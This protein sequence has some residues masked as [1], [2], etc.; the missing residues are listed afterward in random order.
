[1]LTESLKQ[2]KIA[3]TLLILLTAITGLIYPLVVTGLT[4][5]FFP[6]Q[7]NGS[8]IEYKGEIIGSALIGQSF[9]APD[10]FWGRDS[11][12][13]PFPYNAKS[14]TGSNRGPSN[15]AFLM[16]IKSRIQH[17]QKYNPKKDILIP[18]DLVTA[19]ASGLD[20][21]ISP[22]AAFYQAPRIV[23]TNH[24]AEKKIL[25]LI[26]D[27]IQKRDLC[28]LGEPRVNVLELN[29][30]LDKLRSARGTETTQP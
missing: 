1:M 4:Q 13:S 16:A 18:I 12:T 8:L 6:W 19:S 28:L 3:L 21:D 26:T 10:S 11:A 15:P 7:S 22:L 23:A 29:L 27:S 2:I 20:P 30:A 24:I 25:A 17:L 9:T 14:S 5:L